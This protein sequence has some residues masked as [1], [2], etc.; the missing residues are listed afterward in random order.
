MIEIRIKRISHNDTDEAAST[1]IDDPPEYEIH[2]ETLS[3]QDG[4]SI[5]S[6]RNDLNLYNS[7]TAIQAR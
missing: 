1:D 5:S 6:E 7:D 4:Q 2:N 3:R